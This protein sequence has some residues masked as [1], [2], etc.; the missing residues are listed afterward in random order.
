MSRPEEEKST[1][2]ALQVFHQREERVEHHLQSAGWECFLPRRHAERPAPGGVRRV[3]VPAVHGLLFVRCPEG[4]EGGL[5][6]A[7]S[8]C[9]YPAR[10][11]ASPGSRRWCGIPPQE[12]AELRAVSDPGYEGTVYLPGGLPSASRGSRVRVVRG[13]FKGLEGQF[14]RYKNRYYVALS[15]PSLGVL[16]HIPRWYCRTVDPPTA[17]ASE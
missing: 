11:Y 3:L 16:V 12:M 8:S 10:V 2:Y 13:P 14:L 15:V 5:S 17:G 4:A 6:C 7:L 1:W 9:P